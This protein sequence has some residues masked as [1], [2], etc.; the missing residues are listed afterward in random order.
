MAGRTVRI[1]PYLPS[2]WV[3]VCEIHDAARLVELKAAGLDAAYLRLEQTAENEGFHEYEIRVAV[4]DGVVVGFV[5]FTTDELAWLYVHPDVHGQGIGS[6]LIRAALSETQ[7]SMSAEILDGNDAAIAVYRKAGFAF[8]GKEQG[9]M[10][11]NESFGVSV[12]V[13]RHPG[14]A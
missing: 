5:A 6:A 9:R 13:L 8:V 7:A 1:R 4:V 10:P 3:R 11:G 12:T 2:D 14:A